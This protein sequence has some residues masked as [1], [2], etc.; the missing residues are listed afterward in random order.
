MTYIKETSL[1]M[2]RQNPS[3]LRW[4]QTETAPWR[5]CEQPRGICFSGLQAKV[6]LKIERRDAESENRNRSGPTPLVD[7]VSSRKRYLLPVVHF[8][9]WV[10]A[11]L[12]L[13]FSVPCLT[14]PGKVSSIAH[15]CPPFPSTTTCGS[16][17]LSTHAFDHLS[18]H[19]SVSQ[20]HLLWKLLVPFMQD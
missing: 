20:R 7:G 4:Y 10:L 5:K 6:C 13:M 9:G 12:P 8:R 11:K 14:N 17:S 1:Q 3:S 15:T 2:Y 18:G 19:S 16:P